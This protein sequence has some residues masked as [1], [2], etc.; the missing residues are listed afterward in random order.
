MRT[1]VGSVAL[2][3]GGFLLVATVFIAIQ[4]PSVPKWVSIASGCT[5]IAF[6]IASVILL[7]RL[8]GESPGRGMI[9]LPALCLGFAGFIFAV[10][11][12]N[13]DFGKHCWIEGR[14]E[15]YVLTIRIFGSI[16]HEESGAAV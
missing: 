12:K 8:E 11:S 14:N 5:A 7:S 4:F 3:V 1:I 13:Y 9:V 16:L 6:I 10:G 15:V 2:C